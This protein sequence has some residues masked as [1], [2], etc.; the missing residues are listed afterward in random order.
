[1]VG[2]WTRCARQ[3][4]FSLNAI[5]RGVKLAAHVDPAGLFDVV[6]LF[7]QLSRLSFCRVRRGDL[8][9]RDTLAHLISADLSDVDAKVLGPRFFQ[10]PLRRDGR[11]RE[12]GAHDDGR[13]IRACIAQHVDW[14][15]LT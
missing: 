7:A 5:E 12:D 15:L 9:A 13:A 8:V 6:S 4:A 1:M 3:K 14:P 10:H 11:N 2:N